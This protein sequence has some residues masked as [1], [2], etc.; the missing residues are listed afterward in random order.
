MS[1]DRLRV[2]KSGIHGL[3]LFA[4][5]PKEDT[6]AIVFQ[7]G[8]DVAEYT[9][10]I[11]T[12]DDLAGKTFSERDYV[13]QVKRDKKYVDAIRPDSCAARYSNDCHGTGR[14]CNLRWSLPTSG[15]NKGKIIFKATKRIRN[16]EE[17]LIPYGSDYWRVRD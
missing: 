2:K 16:G 11:L 4:V 5:D 6:D 3:G 8:D 17:L 9:G 13:F 14:A 10:E 7:R 12:A 15:D 1:Q